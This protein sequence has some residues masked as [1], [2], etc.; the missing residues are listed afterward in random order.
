M[1]AMRKFQVEYDGYVQGLT[2]RYVE[3]DHYGNI[4]VAKPM[5]MVDHRSGDR[6]QPFL[7][8][9][10]GEESLMQDL[11]DSLWTCGFRPSKNRHVDEILNSKD[12]HLDD[13]RKIAFHSLGI[14]K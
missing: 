6:S 2:L 1:A 3:R 4:K 11:M 8:L 7:V 5:E 9:P 10:D 12:Q 14:S 13:L